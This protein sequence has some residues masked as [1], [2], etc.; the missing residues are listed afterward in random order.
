VL[1]AARALQGIDLAHQYLPDLILTDINLPDMS[2]REIATR[3]RADARLAN[4]PIVALTSF[5][6]SIEREKTLVAGV[7][8]YLT[9]PIDP[10]TLPDKIAAYLGG[11][12]DTL[13]HA[14][15]EIAR[16][17]YNHELVERL[18]QTVR[19]LEAS[20]QELRRLDAIK[21]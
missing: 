5:A 1:V 11:A 17:A 4:V 20:N 10:R 3:L 21:D 13:D 9:K 19:E 18:E 15:A 12:R 6:P 7:A 16:Q 8:G 14:S 2:G